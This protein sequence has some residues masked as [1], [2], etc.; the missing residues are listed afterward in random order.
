M[1]INSDKF[2][3]FQMASLVDDWRQKYHATNKHD[4]IFQNKD[5]LTNVKLPAN[6]L[7]TKHVFNRGFSNLPETVLGPNEVW[8]LWKDPKTQKDVIRNYILLGD[9][10]NYVVQT[11][12]GVIQSAKI[13]VTSKLD[14]VRKGV[15]LLKK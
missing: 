1:K 7:H 15:I 2:S 11:L 5:L 4:I 9:E 12:N 3:M 6:Y 14:R 10:T 13:V 8:S